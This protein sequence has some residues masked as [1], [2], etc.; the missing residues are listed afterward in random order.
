MNRSIQQMLL[1]LKQPTNS[2]NLPMRHIN[3]TSKNSL[4]TQSL[5]YLPMNRQL[6]ERFHSERKS[7]NFLKRK[8]DTVST[9][10]CPNSWATV[11][12]QRKAALHELPGL[13]CVADFSATITCSKIKNGQTTTDLHS[14]VI[15]T[16]T[17]QHIATVS[18]QET[19]ILCVHSVALIFRVLT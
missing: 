2:L 1:F 13:I 6:P 18:T 9:S 4:A 15:W 5:R 7:K 17:I 8:T 16:L 12:P 11:F 19:S 10:S 3:P 14:Q